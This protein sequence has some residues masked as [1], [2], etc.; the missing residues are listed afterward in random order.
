ML[1]ERHGHLITKSEIIE[2]V[3]EDTFVEEG[4]L[5][6][7]IWSIR[8]ALGDTSRAKFIQ[9]VP[10]RGYRFIFPVSVVP[11][12]S[13]AFR[14]LDLLAGV[15]DS[16]TGITPLAEEVRSQT[17]HIADAK[18]HKELD[19]ALPAEPS[20]SR[21]WRRMTAYVG[22][23]VVLLAAVYAVFFGTFASTTKPL[24][25][26]GTTNE[27]A[28]RLYQQA[29]NLTQRRLKK[30]MV[31]ALDYLNQ[32]IMLDPKFARAWAFKAHLHAYLAQYPGADE[33]EEYRKSMD[34]VEKALEI[35]PNVS[36]AYSVRCH[37]KDH[38][39]YDFAGA[40]IDCKRALELDSDSAIG[41]QRYSSFL[42]SRGRF[43]EAIAE[44]KRAVELQPLSFD[45]QQ[46]Y[47]ITLRFARRYVEEEAEW[48]RLLELDPAHS[49]IYTR[50]FTNL[51]QQG[52]YDKAF[53][54]LVK[55]LTEVD[56]ADNETVERFR[57]AYATSGWSGVTIERIKHLDLESMNGPVDV[58]FLYASLGDKD[59][60]FEYLEQAYKER[61]SR[62]ASLQ[63]EPQLDP[64]HDDPRWADLIARIQKH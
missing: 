60:A 8:Q 28:Y 11:N 29:E 19:P 47:A 24:R 7:A 14:S 13:G 6:K 21:N 17:A 3:W 12:G 58:A 32:A 45:S 31:A 27:E 15:E 62:I 37:N 51:A 55:R 38:Y 50:L 57:A 61:N 33:N 2:T 41:H 26:R 22:V 43:D 63:I 30:D 39:E 40:E 25:D 52:K 53:E 48:K 9:T 54:Y 42:R 44:A 35:D 20:R 16:D 4:S 59:K 46:N 36:E 18:D 1:V 56:K 64:L 34:A 5:A 49:L 23:G 10:R